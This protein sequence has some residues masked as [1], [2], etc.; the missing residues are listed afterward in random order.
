MNES[1]AFLIPTS[2]EE[3][4]IERILSMLSR[5]ENVFLHDTDS[6]DR[7]LEIAS[8][9]NVNLLPSKTYTSFSEKCN[10]GLSALYENFDWVFILHADE[11]I[12]ESIIGL[13]NEIMNGKIKK[14]V[15]AILIKRK[16]SF[17]GKTLNYGVTQTFQPRIFRKKSSYYRI[18][19]L[20]E[21]IEINKG[22]YYKVPC[23][24]I[25]L[26][27]ISYRMWIEKH[28]VYSINQARQFMQGDKSR[29]YYLSFSNRIYYQAPLFIRCVILFFYKYIICR[30]FLDGKAGL[31]FN[32]SHN[33]IYR[34][35]VDVRI[36]MKELD[37]GNFKR[38]EILE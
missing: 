7:T 16:L 13:V 36:L 34:I 14:N 21:S 23:E 31:A 27:L 29:K 1:L 22:I 35:M 8:R 11:I 20:D 17:M 6:K 9:F 5:Y 33:L 30:G 2:N 12:T 19:K 37:S 3:I 24:I 26:P 18:S 15:S 38:H 32:I 4:H 10:H 25:D 28:S